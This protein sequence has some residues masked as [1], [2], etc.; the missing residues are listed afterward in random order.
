[1]TVTVVDE[2][3]A[4]V[5]GAEVTIEQPGS[6]I[7]RLATDYNGSVHFELKGTAPYRLRVQKPGF[8]Q[9]EQNS[10]EPQQQD[11]RVVLAHEQ[12][13]VEQVNVSASPPGIDP[14]QVSDTITMAL[15]EIINVPYPTSRDIRNLLPFFPGVVP[16]QSG[17]VHVAGSETWATLDTLDNF[18]IRSPVSGQLAM[19]FSADAVRS[20]DQETT[21]Y[22]VKYGRST[23]GVMAFFTGMGDNKFRFNAT[24]FLPSLHD[25][26]GIRFDKVVPRLTLSGPIRRNRA[27]FFDGLEVEYDDIY[28]PELPPNADTDHLIRGSN[29]VRAQV[30]ATPKNIAS[31]G[32]LFNDYHSPYDGISALVPQ[33]S[34]TKRDTIAWLPYVRDQQ[35]FHS[36]ALLDVGM[37]ETRF[38]DGY[39]PH[40]GGPYELTPE[41]SLGSY[42]ENLSSESQRLEGNALLYLPPRHWFGWHDLQ[43]GLDLDHIQFFES[44]QRA[45][46]NYLR[47]DGTLSRQS[48]FPAIAPFTRHN[49]EV[50][51][52]LQDRWSPRSA[53]LIEPGVRF[54]WDEIIRRPLFAPR[55]AGVWA[56]AGTAGE[57]KVSAGVG[58]YYEHTQLEYLTRSLA[59]IRYDT[60]FAPDGITRTGP[61]FGT[62]FTYNQNDLK[63]AY[64][65]NWS[66]GLEQKLPGA[67]YLKANYINK[68]VEHEFT[69]VPQSDLAAIDGNYLLTNARKDH[70]R[71]EEIEARHTF[72][73]DYTL[74]GAYTHSTAHTNAA[75][76]Y[77]PTT[78]YL[79]PQ[80]PGPLGWDTP[81]RVISW[82]WLPVPLPWFRKRWDIVYTADWHTGFPFTAI[83]ANYKVVGA[84]GAQ[85]FP[86]YKS[87][88][89]GLEWRFHFRG[90]Y[91]GLRGVMENAT[92]SGDYFLVYNDVDSPLYGTFSQP[93][94][95]AFTAR[96][97]LIESNK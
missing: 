61:P 43:A 1:M 94:G 41:T 32:L 76:D 11:V 48:T 39:E 97:R 42:F 63:E 50:G 64:A 23:G 92:N 95:R 60:Y 71:L 88:S 35:S 56:P 19:R 34:T 65:I 72:T 77:I 13:V 78:S 27:W 4:A 51:A 91:L 73:G 3:D 12:M 84:A 9:S 62:T 18:D 8:Y 53:F 15:P 59:G 74:F 52:Y 81:N 17:Q 80:Q 22:P 26:N 86:N 70:D 7:Q 10:L 66:L 46:V 58:L 38:R 67:V 6:T 36:G 45:P 40:P 79:G 44:Y 90:M 28:I 2:N 89:P 14:Q 69:Y 68:T 25:L 30:N 96:I 75:I 93:L 16:D 37:G 47:E 20:I 49:A 33:A 87:Y 83:N 85:R 24:D 5:P 82:G 57:T 55:L 29:L 54:D 21:R 31:A